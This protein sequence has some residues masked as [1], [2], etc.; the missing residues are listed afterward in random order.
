MGKMFRFEPWISS[1]ASCMIYHYA[2]SVHS[3]VISVI[4]TWYIAPKTYTRYLLAGVGRRARVQPRPPLVNPC[5]CP[6]LQ[7]AAVYLT[8]ACLHHAAFL[9]IL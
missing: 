7:V 1:I 4:N 3:M 2:I 6:D 9:E 5:H 8:P